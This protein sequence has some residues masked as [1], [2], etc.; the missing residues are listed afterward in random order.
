[1]T[2]LIAVTNDDGILSPGIKA[3]VEAVMGLG[4]L[5]VVAPSTQQTSMG[6]SLSAKREEYLKPA[7]FEVKGVKVRA[8][9]A[10][11]T[12]AFIV[13]HAMHVLFNGRKPDLLISG[14]NYG[15]NLGSNLT[16]SGTI[17]AAI[18]A[19]TM[20]VPSIALSLQTDIAHHHKYGDVCWQVASHFSNR[21]AISVLANGLPDGVDL[22]NVNVPEGITEQAECRIT[23]QS[24]HPYFTTRVKEPKHDS[25]FGDGRCVVDLDHDG[26]EKDS[27][28]Y[29]IAKDKVVSVTPLRVDMTAVDSHNKVVT[30][31]V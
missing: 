16:I 28:I 13:L 27:D 9:H 1:M 3:A 25:R 2:K 19:A 20:G 5:V 24:R 29:A 31:K 26:L 21:V 7:D 4:E 12:P 6:R 18:Q 22:L 14:I 15:E 30:F 11:S 10:D 17:G 8:Y 23:R